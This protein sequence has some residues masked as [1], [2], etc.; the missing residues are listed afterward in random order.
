MLHCRAQIYRFRGTAALT[1]LASPNV[2]QGYFTP[3]EARQ[4]AIA[5]LQCADDIEARP[6]VN[7]RMPTVL[8]GEENWYENQNR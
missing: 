5:L 3:Q 8:V 4:I 2:D 6:F 1:I 7:S